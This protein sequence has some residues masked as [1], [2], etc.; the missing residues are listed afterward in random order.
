V[1]GADRAH[2]LDVARAAHPGDLG[3]QRRRDLDGVCTDPAAGPV[4]EHPLAG[5]HL[6][7][8]ADPA[9]RRRRRDGDRGRLLEGKARRLGHHQVRRGARVLRERAP[10]KAQH[11]V[12]VAQT[13]HVRA[14]RLHHPRRVDPGHP[15]LR[16]GQPDA[17]EPR[18]QRVP[19]HDVPVGR[20]E[21]GGVHPDQHVA[22]PDLGHAGIRQPQDLRRP[23]PVL[24]DGLHP[25][26]PPARTPR[27]GDRY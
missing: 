11:L 12:A 24:D 10:E 4:D 26:L 9:Q 15:G 17:H 1:R 16:P 25:A 14:G 21:R 18:D 27:R 6:A 5:R 13:A 8:V 22:G 23:E 2:Q 20:I 3:A 7:H 19:S